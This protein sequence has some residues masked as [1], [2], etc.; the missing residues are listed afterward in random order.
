MQTAHSL[1]NGFR[2][3]FIYTPKIFNAIAKYTNIIC[4]I[5]CYVAMRTHTFIP[6][7]TV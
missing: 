2:K 5:H 4:A 6:D 3:Y 7:G 1:S